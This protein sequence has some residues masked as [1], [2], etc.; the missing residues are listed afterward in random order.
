[1]EYIYPPLPYKYKSDLIVQIDIHKKDRDEIETK[2]AHFTGY[3]NIDYRN[4]RNIFDSKILSF[5]IGKL[6]SFLHYILKLDGY[7]CEL[8]QGHL[9]GSESNDLF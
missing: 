4:N 3:E 2:V 1:M 7:D 6:F 5:E 9:H 8:V